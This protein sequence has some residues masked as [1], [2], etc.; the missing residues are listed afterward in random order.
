MVLAVAVV[1]VVVLY[2]RTMQYT[3][4]PNTINTNT[5]MIVLVLVV[6]ATTSLSFVVRSM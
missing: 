5:T 2:S 3:I 4:I 1:L 6:L